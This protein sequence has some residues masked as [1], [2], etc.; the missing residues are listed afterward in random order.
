MAD[1]KKSALQERLDKCKSLVVIEG[2]EQCQ[3]FLEARE[4]HKTSVLQDGKEGVIK[5]ASM[6]VMKA[7][8]GVSTSIP[9]LGVPADD[10]LRSLLELRQIPVTDQAM[11]RIVPWFGSDE[12]VDGD[13][14]IVR[15]NWD[16]GEFKDNSP[17]PFSHNWSQP[18]VGRCIDWKIVQRADQ[19]YTGDAL[20][21]LCMFADGSAWQ[22][23]DSVFRLVNAGVLKGGSVG[24]FST[25]IIDVRDEEERNELGLG[26]FGVIFEENTLLEFSPTTI[27]ANAGAISL[28][29]L[30]TG[31]ADKLQSH[32]MHVVRELLRQH[33]PEIKNPN[34]H[35]AANEEIL[36]SCMRALWPEETY[37]FHKDIE[38]PVTASV[39]VPV[40]E[41]TTSLDSDMKAA[42]SEMMKSLDEFK[43]EVLGK[44]ASLEGSL[45]K[46][47]ALHDDDKD[48]TDKDKRIDDD[49]KDDDK[50]KSR[51]DLGKLFGQIDDL[52]SV[53]VSGASSNS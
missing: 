47:A 4:G 31:V 48:D 2:Y 18:P 50:D 19:D 51:T 43:S 24:F 11:T 28:R 10:E 37:E 41:T 1:K 35:W 3:K 32:D 20:W 5:R 44:F 45:T 27:P 33:L 26:R 22:F 15:Q 52:K 14:D 13:G 30:A 9:G 17:M 34:A 38:V 46:L 25:K 16:F 53:M 29:A 6:P 7:P 49:D 42:L 23:A 40:E 12:R 39:S 8:A 21:L 36:L